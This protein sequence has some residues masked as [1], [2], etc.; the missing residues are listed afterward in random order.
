MAHSGRGHETQKGRVSDPPLFV[1]PHGA[2]T[3]LPPASAED[4]ELRSCGRWTAEARG[5]PPRRPRSSRTTNNYRHRRGCEGEAPRKETHRG[6][7]AGPRSPSRAPCG[8]WVAE[9]RGTPPRR[10]RSS[11]TTNDYQRGCGGE[12]PEKKSSR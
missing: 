1:A 11:R 10:P 3:A 12:A 9:A 8:R 2:H 4:P 5:T 7:G 6:G